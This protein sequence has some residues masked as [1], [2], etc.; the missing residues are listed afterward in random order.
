VALGTWHV[1]LGT[2][3]VALGILWKSANFVA[4]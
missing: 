1:A 2:W 4:L 3:H